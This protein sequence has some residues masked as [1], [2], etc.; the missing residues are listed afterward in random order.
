VAGDV[1]VIDAS[2]Q[3]LLDEDTPALDGLRIAGTLTFDR[4]DLALTSDWILV[5]GTMAVGTEAV[6]FT[7]RAVITLTEE[8]S[9]EDI[10]GMGSRG[11]MV[12]G[13][14]LELH[15]S[16][17]AQTWTQ[18]AAH[19]EPGATALELVESVD[20]SAGD[21]IVIAPTDWYNT[22]ITETS[23]LAAV[24]GSALTLDTP[25]ADFRWG[26]LQYATASG[27][28]LTP[29]DLVTPA[30]PETPTVL[31]E[32]AEVG[33]LT[34][35]IVIQAPD[36][37]LWQ[38][39]GYGAHVMI[40]GPTSIAHVRGVEFRR[41]GQR[42]RLG[43]Y[44]FHWHMLSSDGINVLP[45]A[46]GQYLRDST[47][48]QSAN[49]GVVVHGTNGVL[50]QNNVIYG[51]RGH[52]IFTEDAVERRNTFDGNLMLHV[53]NPLPGNV[54][55]QHEI[56]QNG[57][58]SGIW[59]ANP[60]NI[61][62]NNAAA[63]CQ[64]FGYWLAF[65]A[66]P[67]G[68]NIGVPMR[69]NLVLFG[70]F[71]GNTAHSNGF[72]GLMLDNV[73]I[74]NQGNVFPA[75]YV[76]TIDEMVPVYPR[77]NIRRFY[78]TDFTTWKNGRGGIWDRSSFPTNVGVVSADNVGRFFAGAGEE[79]IIEQC[80]VVG[81]SLNNATPR[82]DAYVEALGGTEIPAAFAT[83][84][85]TFFMRDNVVVNFPL[86]PSERSGV[87]ATDDYYIRPVEKGQIRN[88]DNLLVNS[89]PGYRSISLYDHFVLAGAMLDPYG[90]WGTPGNFLVYDEPFFT[91]GQTPEIIAPG[92]GTGHVGVS[93]PFYGIM[94]F[95][96]NNLRPY[97]HPLMAIDVN[98]LDPVSLATVGTWSVG[99]ASED[100]FLSPFRHFA[101]HRDG[102][103]EL[104]FP[105]SPMPVDLELRFENMLE[106]EDTLVLGVQ[107]SGDVTPGV[108]IRSY[109]RFEV[110]TQA[111][112]L[113][114]VRDSAGATWWQDTANDRVWVKLRGGFWQF[115]DPT[116]ET[117]APT[118]DD[119]LYETTELHLNTD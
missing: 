53:R 52:A 6:P 118:D 103:Y 24:S 91:Y 110:Y 104:T 66:N 108:Y 81:D 84:H 38:D 96:I 13:G 51:T 1:V 54:L 32:R 57:G 90:I 17:P 74:D 69:P 33:N 26:L 40:M 58:S 2:M 47:I 85:S 95:V 35:N 80:L 45:D 77:E 89:H 60:D 49:R 12:M 88:T 109:G 50:V 5:Q 102:I 83:Y 112:S 79:G 105:D 15:G 99:A 20:W 98:R 106:E 22:A 8:N 65:P 14:D 71:D 87:F 82:P 9:D 28:S 93:G 111:G 113:Q 116:F 56:F 46:T 97:Y 76:S 64:G 43:R 72:E 94:Q 119:L 25:L 70:V 115:F 44:P 4:K 7:H 63:D 92:A 31:D 34:R 67:W 41:G 61:T 42:G 55:K 39:E 19:A 30:H 62:T 73:E 16:P 75:Q 37:T 3:V 78:L 100:L 117:A 59:V 10:M 107:F 23:T 68:L 48:N 27:M 36:D 101:A 29:E 11:I 86:V 21:E 18:I 114:A